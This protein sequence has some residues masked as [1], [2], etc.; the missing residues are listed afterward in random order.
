MRRSAPASWCS[1]CGTTTVGGESAS[2]SPLC[3][4]LELNQSALVLQSVRVFFALR[5]GQFVRGVERAPFI[6]AAAAAPPIIAAAAALYRGALL[7]IC[8]VAHVWFGRLVGVPAD[9]AAAGAAPRI[10]R[11]A[12]RQN[13]HAR[14]SVHP[15]SSRSLARCLRIRW[16]RTD[17]SCAAGVPRGRLSLLMTCCLRADRRMSIRRFNLW[18]W[19]NFFGAPLSTAVSHNL[20]PLSDVCLSFGLLLTHVCAVCPVC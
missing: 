6:A 3:P 20:T 5:R 14:R 13:A 15:I 8:L 11:P 10:P 4:C 19:K 18:T 17:S 16:P 7:M 1:R 2:Q 12:R 9:A